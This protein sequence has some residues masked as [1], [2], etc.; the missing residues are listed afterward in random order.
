MASRAPDIGQVDG[1]RGPQ[2]PATRLR[3]QGGKAITVEELSQTPSPLIGFIYET[4]HFYCLVNRSGS[5]P[6]TSVVG[7]PQA[8]ENWTRKCNGG[9]VDEVPGVVGVEWEERG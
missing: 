1:R 8:D 5:C 6:A 9:G 7:W 3:L 4:T 2:T